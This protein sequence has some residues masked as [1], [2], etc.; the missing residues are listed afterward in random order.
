MNST[1][2]HESERAGGMGG[3]ARRRGGLA[4]SGSDGF[5]I[6]GSSTVQ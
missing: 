4:E 5:L 6:I 1:V 3:A 2:I